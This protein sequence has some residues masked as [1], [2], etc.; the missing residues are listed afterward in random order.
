M[1][2]KELVSIILVLFLSCGKL[3]KEIIN[4]GVE[5]N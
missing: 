5:K 4:H 1:M 3:T 2:K